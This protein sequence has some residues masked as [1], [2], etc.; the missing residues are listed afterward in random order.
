MI[1][2][3]TLHGTAIGLP[4]SWDG[5]GGQLIGIYG[6]PMECLGY[7]LPHTTYRFPLGTPW[8]VQVCLTSCCWTIL[9]SFVRADER[10]VLGAFG[11]PVMIAPSIAIETG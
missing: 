9:R 8:M 6:I 1:L 3:Q 5:F 4:I 10:E 11:A 2:T 7:V